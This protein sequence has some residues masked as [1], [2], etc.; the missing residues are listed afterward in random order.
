MSKRKIIILIG[1]VIIVVLVF[2]FWFLLKP[3][4]D[5]GEKTAGTNFLSTIFP[6]G[7]SKVQ[8]TETT[9]TTNVSGFETAPTAEILPTRLTKVSSF[10]VAGYGVFMKERFVEVPPPP[11]PPPETTTPPPNLPLTK[12]EEKG[13]G[14]KKPTPPPTEFISALRYVEKA[15]GNIYQT[16]ADNIDERKFTTTVIPKVYDAYFGN[17]GESVVMRYLGNDERTV[18]T[19]VGI[20]PK[21]FLGG[22]TTEKT[23]ITG[24]FLPENISDISVAPDTVKLFYLSG[25]ENSAVGIILDA[26]A[27]KKS[28]IFSSP[29]TEWLSWWPNNRMITFTTKPSYNVPGYMYAVDPDK[30]PASAGWDFNKILGGINGLTTLTSPNGKLVLYA[31]N[32]LTLSMFDTDT[33]ESSQLGIKTLPEK[34]VWN[35]LSEF[36]YCAVPKNIPSGQYPDSWYQ[37]EV[38]FSDEIWY[39]D[40]LSG[41]TLLALEPAGIEGGE[42]IDAIKLTI[43]ENQDYLFFVNKKDSYLWKFDL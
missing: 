31:N 36:V 43:D 11:P 30:K 6:F 24:S 4:N 13:G 1:L 39:I 34:C 10:P 40:V 29:F 42:E 17:K 33:R 16:F 12:G 38:S 25:T 14:Q 28:Q 32:N 23:G 15:T 5:T 7:K 18:E 27:D 3:A 35:K 37:G 21:E 8:P 22:D 41:S 19:F 2:G 20:L 9:P 26:M